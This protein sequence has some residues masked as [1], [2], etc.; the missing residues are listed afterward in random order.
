[1]LQQFKGISLV[2]L[3]NG[4]TCFLWHD[5][6][7][8]NIWSQTYPEL[9]FFLLEYQHYNYYSAS[10]SS[11]TVSGF[12]SSTFIS[13]SP[14]SILGAFPGAPEFKFTSGCG[15]LDLYLGISYFFLQ[16]SL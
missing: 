15:Q 3:Q 11:S 16:Q 9:L 10:C 6:W 1:M 12:V 13:R 14:C 8:G 5:L 4:A 2:S 7:E